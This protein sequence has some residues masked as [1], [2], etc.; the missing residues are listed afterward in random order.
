MKTIAIIIAL[1]TSAFAEEYRT[2]TQESSKKTIEA[3]LL[4]K[5][6]S[7][8][9]IV[10][11]DGKSYWLVVSTLSLV[12]QA[13]V[14]DW[15]RKPMGFKPLV[16]REIGKP[17]KGKATLSVAAQSWDKAATLEVFNSKTSSIPIHTEKLEPYSKTDWSGDVLNDYRVVLKD[18]DGNAIGEASAMK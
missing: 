15:Q 18:T 13:Y 12:D 7:R 3:K 9:R 6:D 11:K 5:D 1:A 4:D 17:E 14:K 10:A 2:W 16:V 8:A